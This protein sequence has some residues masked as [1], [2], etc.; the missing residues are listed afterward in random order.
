MIGALF[1]TKKIGIFESLLE[2]GGHLLFQPMLDFTFHW[3]GQF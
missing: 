3:P 1:Y 2:A